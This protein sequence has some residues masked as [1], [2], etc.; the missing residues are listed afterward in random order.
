MNSSKRFFIM[1][2][3]D[4]KENTP[5]AAGGRGATPSQQSTAGD[6]VGVL[7]FIRAISHLIAKIH[8]GGGI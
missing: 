1:I 4:S 7:D 8:K 3:K 5:T 6:N 2:E